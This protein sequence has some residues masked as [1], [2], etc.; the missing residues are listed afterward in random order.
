MAERKKENEELLAKL[1]ALA[2]SDA[3]SQD[4][5]LE[6]T[7]TEQRIDHV[8]GLMCSGQWV[9]GT[10]HR[11][12]AELWNVGVGTIETYAAEAS[13]VIRR[14]VR[15]SPEE[16]AEMRARLIQTF[17][18]LGFKAEQRGSERG[19]RDAIEAYKMLAMLH[20]AVQQR[21]E[22]SE[23]D[24]FEGWS[25]EDKER[26]VASGAMPERLQKRGIGDVGAQ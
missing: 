16:R 10:S 15:E 7:R 17:E 21:V 25:R 8:V 13:R 24:P 20:G 9:S 4:A 1:R 12:M 2:K 5:E 22:I 6:R 23:P 19:F 26:F 18:R 14:L 11:Q 3:E